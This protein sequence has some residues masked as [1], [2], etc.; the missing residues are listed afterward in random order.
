MSW[1]K[2]PETDPRFFKW[3]KRE[4]LVRSFTRTLWSNDG[5]E[6]IVM[7]LEGLIPEEKHSCEPEDERDFRLVSAM[8]R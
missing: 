2:I 8:G 4:N 5:C 6:C 3:L 7:C 1:V